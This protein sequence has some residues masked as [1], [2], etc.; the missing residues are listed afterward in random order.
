M[1]HEHFRTSFFIKI[2]ATPRQYIKTRLGVLRDIIFGR[3]TLQYKFLDSLAISTSHAKLRK[4][5]FAKVA[6]EIPFSREY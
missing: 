4:K 1:F 5:I 3:L 2:R 6:N